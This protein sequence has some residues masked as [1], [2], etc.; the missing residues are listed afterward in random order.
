MRFINTW[1]KMNK[2]TFISCFSNNKKSARADVPP[3]STKFTWVVTT[4]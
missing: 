1:P 4:S 3:I 2:K